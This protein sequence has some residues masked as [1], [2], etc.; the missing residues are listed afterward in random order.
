M[1]YYIFVLF[2]FL[3]F[4]YWF[5]HTGSNCILV[6]CLSSSCYCL[7]GAIEQ[8]NRY[9]F[10]LFTIY[11]VS[12]MNTKRY[13]FESYDRDVKKLM[14]LFIHLSDGSLSTVETLIS[15]ALCG[16]IHSIIGGQ[17]LLIL[18]VAEPTIIMYT[19]LYS[20]TKNRP[21]MGKELFL[22]WAGWW[23]ISCNI[24]QSSYSLCLSLIFF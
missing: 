22:A 24:M 8:R 11:I 10:S 6:L 13:E 7:W 17:P 2:L 4:L 16:I 21:D 18:G 3:F 9:F 20:F 12:T 5:Q 19:Y 14:E 15:T 1:T 23:G